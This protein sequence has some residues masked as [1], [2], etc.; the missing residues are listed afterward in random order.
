MESELAERARGSGG[1]FGG[2][3]AVLA[4]L[5]V[6]AA[7]VLG[8]AEG[9]ASAEAQAASARSASFG[10]LLLEP[11]SWATGECADGAFDSFEDDD[12]SGEGPSSLRFRGADSPTARVLRVKGLSK[13]APSGSHPA[14]G[15]PSA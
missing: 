11:G 10:R 15:P 14:R 9:D 3:F 12:L 5:A 8:P 1:R 2:G 6:S 4:L 7:V 13:S